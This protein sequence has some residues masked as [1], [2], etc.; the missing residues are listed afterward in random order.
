MIFTTKRYTKDLF[1]KNRSKHSSVLLLFLLRIF[2]NKS[3]VKKTF[4]SVTFIACSKYT[5]S[6]FV[7]VDH[8][9]LGSKMALGEVGMSLA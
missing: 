1:I 6:K 7:W 2:M 3:F 9:Q 4:I 5:G 8:K